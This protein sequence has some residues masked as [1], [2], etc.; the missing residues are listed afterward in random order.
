MEIEYKLLRK[1]PRAKVNEVLGLVATWPITIRESDPEWRTQA[2]A[3]KAAGRISLA[4]AWIASLA[5]LL[6]AELVHKDP[7]FDKVPR[8]KALRLPYDRVES[9][10]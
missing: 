6:D 10:P 1:A 9:T 4:D 3:V 5:L 8:L 2:A 7:E